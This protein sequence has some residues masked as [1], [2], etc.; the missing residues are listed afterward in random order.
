MY[1]DVYNFLKMLIEKHGQEKFPVEEIT[2]VSQEQVPVVQ[3]LI[4]NDYLFA[5]EFYKTSYVTRSGIRAY[6]QETLYRK[7]Q[8]QQQIKERTSNDAAIEIED[9]KM[10][11]DSK[12]KFC[13]DILVAVAS[14]LISGA[15]I[16][17]INNFVDVIAYA[18]DAF[19]SILE[20]FQSLS[21]P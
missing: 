14:T 7:N 20:W 4:D 5:H 21:P 11:K 3:E 19:S 17:I 18:H 10:H 1:D 13:R 9:A 6:Q 2:S 8:L 15:V 12:K 16:Y